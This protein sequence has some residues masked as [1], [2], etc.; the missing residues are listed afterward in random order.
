[1]AGGGTLLKV[2]I[3]HFSFYLS[4]YTKKHEQSVCIQYA[5]L[6]ISIFLLLNYLSA[7]NFFS[8]LIKIFTFEG[9]LLGDTQ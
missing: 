5:F 4:F 8:S 6:I 9:I 3:R 7:L 2:K 1:M